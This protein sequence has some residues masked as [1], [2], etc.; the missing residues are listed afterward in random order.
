MSLVASRRRR[1]DHPALARAY[2]SVVDRADT[3]LS[4]FAVRLQI[5]PSSKLSCGLSPAP[6]TP[7]ARAISFF[8]TA[9]TWTAA[10]RVTR[11]G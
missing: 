5:H 10:A 6:S 9:R 4:I 2:G 11:S 7:I 1:A 3:Y 8:G